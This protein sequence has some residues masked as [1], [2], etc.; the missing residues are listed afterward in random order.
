MLYF[1]ELIL[2]NYSHGLSEGKSMG[3]NNV[4]PNFYASSIVGGIV[5]LSLGAAMGVKKF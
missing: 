4:S 1:M 3:T 5:P 2:K